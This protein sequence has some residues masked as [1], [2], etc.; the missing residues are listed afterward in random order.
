LRQQ[1]FSPQVTGACYNGLD[2]APIWT[3]TY[4]SC[5]GSNHCDRTFNAAVYDPAVG[6]S[7]K[8]RD[9]LLLQYLRHSHI[10]KGNN[11]FEPRHQPSV[12]K[13]ARNCCSTLVRNPAGGLFRAP[14]FL[15]LDVCG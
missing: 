12:K 7:D 10:K 3:F 4:V 13:V 8:Q 15:A 6:F 1:T 9:Q 14:I 5:G 11:A 2:G